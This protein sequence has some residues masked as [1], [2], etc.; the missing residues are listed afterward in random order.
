MYIPE[1]LYKVHDLVLESISNQ[2]SY[3]DYSDRRLKRGKKF[4]FEVNNQY[5]QT[6][7]KN[8]IMAYKILKHTYPGE[9][10]HNQQAFFDHLCALDFI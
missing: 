6:S 8:L 7:H 9:N 2:K 1:K 10:Q 4:G 3:F 5:I